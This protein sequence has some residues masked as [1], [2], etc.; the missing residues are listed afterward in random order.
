MTPKQLSPDQAAILAHKNTKERDFWISTW[1][2]TPATQEGEPEKSNFPFTYP[3]TKRRDTEIHSHSFCLPQKTAEALRKISGGSDHKLNAILV[4]AVTALINKYTGSTDVILGTPIYKQEK[5]I[6]LPTTH[7]ILRSTFAVNASFKQVL[8]TT[9]RT[10]FNAV[11]HGNYPLHMLP[12]LLGLAPHVPGDRYPFFDIVVLLTNIHNIDPIRELSPHI[13]FAFTC[14]GQ[15]I[16]G[17]LEYNSSLYDTA[18][19]QGIAGHL[20]RLME[21]LPAHLD[22]PLPHLD[23][24]SESERHKVINAF[25][26]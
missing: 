2:G 14:S 21:L 7:V 6:P 26:N 15:N 1:T 5:D 19:I 4:A 23:I 20:N 24:L 3:P 18:T 12:E 17:L 13:L 9:A 10:I 11:A 16:E 25:N 22:T 8:T